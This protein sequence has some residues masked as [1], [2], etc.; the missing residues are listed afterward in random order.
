MLEALSLNIPLI[1]TPV[2]SF[3]ELG[4]LDKVN[5]HVVPFD[6]DFDVHELLDIPEYTFSYDN[7]EKI[8]KWKEIL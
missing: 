5:A 7:A 3:F 2:P 8:K 4:V 1:C 6:M